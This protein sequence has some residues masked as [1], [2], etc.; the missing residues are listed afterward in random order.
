MEGVF[1]VRDPNSLRGKHVLLIDDVVTTGASLEACG[2]AIL[3]V[4]ETRLSIA[5]VAYT[6]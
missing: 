2:S 5:T 4:P 3:A 1:E 6:I